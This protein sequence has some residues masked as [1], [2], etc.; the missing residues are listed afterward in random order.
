[1]NILDWIDEMIFLLGN[2]EVRELISYDG[3]V[4]KSITRQRG[5]L[6][7]SDVSG[8][9]NRLIKCVPID[10]KSLPKTYTNRLGFELT[11][12]VIKKRCKRASKITYLFVVDK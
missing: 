6:K 8:K 2:G 1:M 4:A 9:P 11:F 5:K 12:T 7:V 10:D 3:C